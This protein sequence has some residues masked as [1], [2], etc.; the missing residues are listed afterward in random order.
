V[1]REVTCVNHHVEH[2]MSVPEFAKFM[3]EA[4]EEVLC[5]ELVEQK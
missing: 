4:L 2:P 1:G 3:K 5:I